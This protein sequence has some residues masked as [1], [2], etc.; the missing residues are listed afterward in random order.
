M[1]VLH[2]I[3][4]G[5]LIMA[6]RVLFKNKDSVTLLLLFV[7]HG[8]DLKS[9]TSYRKSYSVNW[10]RIYLKNNAAKFHRDPIWKDGALG[11]LEVI[12][13]PRRTR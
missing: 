11:F 8:S 12:A 10:F 13:P 6:H 7:R 3:L 1:K 5:P 2:K 9:M 4:R